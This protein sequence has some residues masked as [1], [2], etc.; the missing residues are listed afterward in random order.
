MISESTATF[1]CV[2]PAAVYSNY[3]MMPG[4]SMGWAWGG[5]LL[6]FAGKESSSIHWIKYRVTELEQWMTDCTQ[7]RLPPIPP[8][9]LPRAGR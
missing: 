9:I 2:G 5:Y 6:Y 4:I 3:C 1:H 7:G 8:P